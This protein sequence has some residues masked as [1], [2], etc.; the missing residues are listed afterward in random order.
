MENIHGP[1]Q[2]RKREGDAMKNHDKRHKEMSGME[3]KRDRRKGNG[4]NIHAASPHHSVAGEETM[5]RISFLV[6]FSLEEGQIKGKIT[7]R[8][9]NKQVDF[10]GL[11][12]AAI[13]QF[14]KKYLSRLEKGAAETADRGPIEPIHVELAGKR[15]E[16]EKEI[17]SDEIRT[18]SFS[19]IPAGSSQPTEM[20]LQGQPLQL[21]WCFEPSADFAFRGERMNYKVSICRKK[22]AGG[23]RELLGEIGGEINFTDPVTACI[24]SEPLPPGTYRIEADAEFSLKSKKAAWRRTCHNS[25]LIQVD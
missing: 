16:G 14:M 10:D 17:S 23:H 11:D 8:L 4:D 19:V 2:S 15:K 9:T 20:I 7:H 6:D 1:R 25:S 13:T 12:Q 18:R 3:E 24:H 21:Q 22:L 5:A